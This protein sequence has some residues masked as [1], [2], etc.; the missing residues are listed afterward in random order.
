MNISSTICLFS[1]HSHC[2]RAECACCA[3]SRSVVSDSWDPID[4][5][6]PG[7][8]VQGILQA[9]ILEWVTI[10]FSRGSFQ[11]R[12][13]TQ[14]YCIAVRLLTDWGYPGS[15][16]YFVLCQCPLYILI[17]LQVFIDDLSLSFVITELN[18]LYLT[19]CGF[20]YSYSC[21]R[22]WSISCDILLFLCI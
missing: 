14:V 4:C 3:L 2:A 10:S 16:L 5:S 11:P 13:W 19:L 18:M 7:S 20:L 22:P 6:L 15:P 1:N 9:R 8:F 12:D 21:D 17:V